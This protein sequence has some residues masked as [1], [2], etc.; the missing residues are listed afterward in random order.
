MIKKSLAFLCLFVFCY[1]ITFSQNGTRAVDYNTRSIGRGGTEIGFFDGPSAMLMNP[2]GISF[3]KKPVLNANAIFMVP[4]T[5][6][7]N[8]VKD[9]SGNPTTQLL[10]DDDG[11]KL[12]YVMPSLAYVHDFKNSK[13]TLG[14]GVFTTGGMGTEGK[15]NHQL[16]VSPVFSTNYQ[17]Q[18]YRSRF[19]VIESC[20][21]GSYLIT[22][23]FS[24]GITGEF[25]YSTLELGQP[26]SLSP[27]FL[28]GAFVSALTGSTTYG[29]YF[30]GN[31]PLGLGYKELTASAEMTN[32]KSYTF[33]GKIGF[34]YKCSE[35]FSLGASYTLSV[36]LNYKDGNAKMDMS[37]QFNEASVVATQNVMSI[38][39]ISADSAAKI[40]S[41]T[42]SANGIHPYEGFIADY[43]VSNEFKTPQSVGFGLMY[44]PMPK[45]RLGFDFEWLNWSKAF[46][47]MT[48]TLKGGTNSNINKMLVNGA[49]N[50]EDLVVEFPMNWKDAVILK[51]GG[52]YD[53]SKVFTVRAGYSYSSNPIPEETIIPIMPAILEHH[54]MAGLS[55][56]VYTKLTLN[57]AL[58]YGLK[59]SVTGSNP[60]LVATEYK[61]SESSLQNLLAH[62]SLSYMF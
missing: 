13:F 23:Q 3:I 9:A 59:N 20:I 40:V 46:D 2:A 58:E 56:D 4:P 44:S 34:A 49:P 7:K 43:T 42:F 57:L 12:L 39:H 52:E 21:S 38:L 8:Y 47:K 6:F 26:F 53:L 28:K 27:S 32:L 29:N 61:N 31:K 55:Y 51:F 19:A 35:K 22:P 33:G 36:P 14:A 62:I 1:S 45:C 11:E 30:S 50:A 5:H 48:L 37:A 54:I 60:H 15:F 18:V 41:A 17:K 10:N 24:I 16:F 25:V